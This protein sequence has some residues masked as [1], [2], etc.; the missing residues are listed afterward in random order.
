MKRLSGYVIAALVLCPTGVAQAQTP[1]PVAPVAPS[2]PATPATPVESFQRLLDIGTYRLHFEVTPGTGVPI[3]LEAGGGD[4]G[5]VWK[6]IVPPLAAVTGAPVIVYDRVGLGKSTAPE[7]PS[8]FECEVAAL[9]GGLAQLG[10]GG[11]IVLVAHSLGGLYATLYAA[12]HPQE[13]QATVFVDANLA[14]FF[15]AE[16]LT[17]MTASPAFRATVELLRK[18]PFPPGIPVTDIVAERTLFDGTP[19]AERWK[20]C[21]RDFVAAFP[22][23][24]EIVALD[25]GHYV[26]RSNAPLV[27]KAIVTAYATTAGIVDSAR[28][29]AIL[30]RAYAQALVADN[31]GKRDR[32]RYAHSEDD[33][34]EWGYSLL[35]QKLPAQAVE[36]F[37]LN[38]TL[39][40]ESAN[41]A[42]S[43]AEGYETVG[44]ADN[45]IRSYRKAL[46]LDPQMTHARERLKALT[47]VEC[48]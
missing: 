31:E 18:T 29:A 46:E 37:R 1:A 6:G 40:P 26:F 3:L 48:K 39:H 16:Q 36:V 2:T 27:L 14:C 43:L 13:V 28:R 9:E 5:S 4:D 21:H 8:C 17:A 15:T 24:R 30:E 19:D 25:S 33:L 34:N 32:A 41:A 47:E 42:D 44:D 22:S 38:V 45:A 12:R 7:T 35:K 20:A 11:D 10:Y 23:R